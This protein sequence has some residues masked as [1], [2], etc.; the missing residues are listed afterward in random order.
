MIGAE[1]TTPPAKEPAKPFQSRFLPANRPSQTQSTPT[2]EEEEETETD[3]SSE[4]ET[5][6]ES[7]EEEAK[8]DNKEMSKSDIGK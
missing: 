8:K 3:T 2:K 6:T 7:E 4:E 1:P 5:E